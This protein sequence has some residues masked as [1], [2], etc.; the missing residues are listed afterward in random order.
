MEL[1]MN[2]NTDHSNKSYEDLESVHAGV[3]RLTSLYKKRLELLKKELERCKD[4]NQK[5]HLKARVQ[6]FEFIVVDLQKLLT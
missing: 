3:Q 5:E 2:N 4:S 6:I 1:T